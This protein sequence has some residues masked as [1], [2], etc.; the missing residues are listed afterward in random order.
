MILE[1]SDS[2]PDSLVFVL[3]LFKQL[4]QRLSIMLPS[5]RLQLH[6]AA[7]AKVR[8]VFFLKI[9]YKRVPALLPIPAVLVSTPH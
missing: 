4:C 1:A 3:L 6:V 7:Y 8:T 2:A 5:Q 9:A